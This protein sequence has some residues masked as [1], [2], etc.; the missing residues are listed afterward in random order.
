MALRDWYLVVLFEGGSGMGVVWHMA[1]RGMAWHASGNGSDWRMACELRASASRRACEWW[2]HA[3]ASAGAEAALVSSSSWRASSAH[4]P[5]TTKLSDASSMYVW[6][7]RWAVG[8]TVTL[9]EQNTFVSS[10]AFRVRRLLDRVM[11]RKPTEKKEW[12]NKTGVLLW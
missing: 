7:H 10:M 4:S 3:E 6:R 1:W 2:H 12:R 8:V 9:H 11:N 5:S